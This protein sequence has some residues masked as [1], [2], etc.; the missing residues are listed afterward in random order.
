VNDYIG[1]TCKE[2]SNGVYY[3]YK[4][5]DGPVVYTFVDQNGNKAKTDVPVTKAFTYLRRD[6]IT[7]LGN[8]TFLFFG[9][10]Q[11]RILNGDLRGEVIR[12][13]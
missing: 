13:D 3:F 9:A 12:I 10:K 1:F 8:N 7:D 4:N 6:F 5:N 11:E 2:I